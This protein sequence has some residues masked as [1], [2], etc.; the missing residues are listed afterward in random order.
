MNILPRLREWD[1]D[2]G[3]GEGMLEM[4]LEACARCVSLCGREI[5]NVSHEISI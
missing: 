1:M 2:K 5:V 3:P 4:M